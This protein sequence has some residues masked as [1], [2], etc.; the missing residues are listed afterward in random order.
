MRQ[1]A[2]PS[3]CPSILAPSGFAGL[4]LSLCLLVSLFL[5]LPFFVHPPEPCCRHASRAWHGREFSCG[6]V[7]VPGACPGAS[8]HGQQPFGNETALENPSGQMIISMI[9]AVGIVMVK[10]IVIVIVFLE[11]IVIVVVVVVVVVVVAAAAVV[12]ISLW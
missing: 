7:L 6:F 8:G 5:S 10:A 4:S 2:H 12:S 9:I 1:H 11:M 3:V